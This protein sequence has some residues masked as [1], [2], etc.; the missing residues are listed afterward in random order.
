MFFSYEC[1]KALLALTVFH[2]NWPCLIAETR[3]SLVSSFTYDL[4]PLY[5]LKTWVILKVGFVILTSCTTKIENLLK[6][7]SRFSST[8]SASNILEF[9]CSVLFCWF[10][11]TIFQSWFLLH[12]SE[13][14]CLRSFYFV[15]TFFFC[16]CLISRA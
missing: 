3:N 10:V 1:W 11:G 15:W 4:Y 2:G 13:D 6:T 8:I 9:G 16:E 12:I 7:W 5:V 14:G